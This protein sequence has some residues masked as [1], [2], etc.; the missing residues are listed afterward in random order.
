MLVQREWSRVEES[1][2]RWVPFRL[3]WDR[4]KATE[5]KPVPSDWFII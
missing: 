5:Q 4:I 3:S 1:L 2:T